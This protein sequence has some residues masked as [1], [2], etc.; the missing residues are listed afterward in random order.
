M[1][2]PLIFEDESALQM[3]LSLWFCQLLGTRSLWLV[4]AFGRHIVFVLGNFFCDC[5]HGRWWEEP[6]ID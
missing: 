6:R 2:I 1:R 3:T 4:V 5:A